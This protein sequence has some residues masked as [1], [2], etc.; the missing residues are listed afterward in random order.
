VFFIFFTAI[1]QPGGIWTFWDLAVM[2]F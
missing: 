2:G 1:I